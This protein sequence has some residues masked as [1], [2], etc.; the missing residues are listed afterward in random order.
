MLAYAYLSM[1]PY[2][3]KVPFEKAHAVMRSAAIEAVRLDPMLAEAHAARGWVHAA[4]FE[5][6]EAERAFRR[7]IDLNPRAH[8]QLY[9]LHV[10]H[11]AT[12]RAR[13]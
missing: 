10:L 2:Q 11:A 5:W 3:S 7:A 9:Q 1:S 4:E 13:G 8:L 12:A 6:V